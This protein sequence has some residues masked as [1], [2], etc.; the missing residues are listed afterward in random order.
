MKLIVQ[1]G[2]PVLTY[3]KTRHNIGF[4]VIDELAGQIWYATLVNRNS[5]ASTL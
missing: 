4:D 5:M 1:L 2:N 3:D